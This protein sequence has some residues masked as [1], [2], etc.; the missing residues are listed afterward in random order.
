VKAEE[1][2]TVTFNFPVEEFSHLQGLLKIGFLKN[3]LYTIVV[4]YPNPKPAFFCRAVLKNQ[5]QKV[6]LGV[7]YNKVQ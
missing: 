3:Q 5:K 6:G 1:K 2:V 7:L 4:P